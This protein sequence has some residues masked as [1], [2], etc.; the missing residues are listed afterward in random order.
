MA[1]SLLPQ[2]RL[3]NIEG[4]AAPPGDFGPHLRKL[5]GL[6]EWMNENNFMDICYGQEELHGPTDAV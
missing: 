1:T 6:H 3:S 2:V 4:R 5:L